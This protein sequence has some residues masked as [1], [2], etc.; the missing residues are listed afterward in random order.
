LTGALLPLW[1]FRS[2]RGEGRTW[3]ERALAKAPDGPPFDRAR[4]LFSQGRLAF[5]QGDH[6]LA[7]RALTESYELWQRLND[8]WGAGWSLLRL[9]TVALG[10]GDFDRAYDLVQRAL[11]TLE[12]IENLD[13]IAN[14]RFE[15]SL[16]AIG[17]GHSE[18]SVKLLLDALTLYRENDDAWGAARCLNALA[19]VDVNLGDSA[20]ALGWLEQ[21]LPIWHELGTKEGLVEWLGAVAAAAAG[22]HQPETALVMFGAVDTA[23]RTLGYPFQM[24]LRPLF[25]RAQKQAAAMVSEADA[26]RS[27]AEGA[28]MPFEQALA[29]ATAFLAPTPPSAQPSRSPD[30]DELTARERD[31]LRLL[32]IGQSNP[33]IAEALYISRGTVKT[34]VANIFAKLGARSRTEAADLARRRGIL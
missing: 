8:P 31:V 3:L 9:G 27:L 14:C 22:R 15:L 10:N 20:S 26:D 30:S 24:P 25:E 2:Y 23:S 5:L 6:G 33:A 4:A 16:V 12:S 34:H 1:L 28:A 32:V 7:E 13:G 17:Q 18:E 29:L 21:A 11:H 19:F